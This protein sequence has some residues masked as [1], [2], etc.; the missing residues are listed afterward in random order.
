VFGGV[1]LDFSSVKENR[2][3]VQAP[4]IFSD[5]KDLNEQGSDFSSKTLPETSCISVNNKEQQ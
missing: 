2:T 4:K 5:S 3:Q 1:R